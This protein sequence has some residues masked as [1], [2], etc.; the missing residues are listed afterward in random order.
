[1]QQINMPII[2]H[3]QHIV[4]T[5]RL[6][7]NLICQKIAEALDLLETLHDQLNEM[8]KWEQIT[9]EFIEELKQLSGPKSEVYLKRN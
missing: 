6:I 4:K 1:M 7:F 2:V 8:I 5:R 3:N 9:T